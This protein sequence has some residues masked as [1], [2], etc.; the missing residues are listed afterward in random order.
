M[1]PASSAPV[2]ILGVEVDV[3]T[4]EQLLAALRRDLKAGR[5][6]QVVTV[7]NEIIMRAAAD[8]VYRKIVNAADY[9]IPDSVGTLW[10][11]S[12][13]AKPLNGPFKGLR[14]RTQAG[15][16]LV[17]LA[18]GSKRAKRVIT[19]TVPGSELAFDLA[20]LCAESGIG[21]HLLGGGPGVAEAAAAR[22]REQYPDLSV[23]G[24][25]HGRYVPS[26]ASD[27]TTRQ[28]V[29]A[30]KPAVVLVA[31]GAPK[32]EQWISR[33]LAALPKPMIAVGVGGTL[34]Y[35]AGTESIYGGGTAKQPPSAV[36]QRGFEWLWRLVT[37]PSRWRR[38]ITAFPKFVSAVIRQKRDRLNR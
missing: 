17:A 33:N 23:A 11:A 20:A 27:R 31:Y 16:L 21:L 5:R 34:D 15:G 30:T 28:A 37:Q 35:V 24:S 29:T 26:A 10:A 14:L 2:D 18:F 3:I 12:Y 1:S 7:T 19:E 8:P 38:I 6:V 36:R 32:Q 4:R 25:G 13:L 9:R 22:L